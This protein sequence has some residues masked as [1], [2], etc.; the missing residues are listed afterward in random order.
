[1]I[2]NN[3]DV[4]FNR[5]R[6]ESILRNE[7]IIFLFQRFDFNYSNDK[8]SEIS[9]IT[10]KPKRAP[11]SQLIWLHK[12][13]V[14]LYFCSLPFIT[15]S[16][17]IGVKLEE[18]LEGKESRPQRYGELGTFSA[19]Q[20]QQL[21]ECLSSNNNQWLNLFTFLSSDCCKSI[22]KHV[23]SDFL[24]RASNHFSISSLEKN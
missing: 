21:T 10:N 13:L 5:A 8:N 19:S 17:W 20:V 11:H 3:C 9:Q 1:M 16:S 18:A 23:S 6:D 24:F 2:A 14:F 15:E 12:I 7:E 22:W 4:V